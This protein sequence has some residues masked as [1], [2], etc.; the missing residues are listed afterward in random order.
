MKVTLR[1]KPLSNGSQS[2][3]LDVYEKGERRYE[4][5]R[6]YLVPEVDENTKLLNKNAL[7]KAN[8]IKS[9]FI[10]G[11]HL[12]NTANT[13]TLTLVEWF[14]E[15]SRRMQE[16]RKVS[17]AV[18]DHLHLLRP[19]LLGFLAESK[20]KNIKVDAFGRK[21]LLDFLSY[22]KD[23]KCEKRERLSQGTMVIYQQR[24]VALFNAAIVEGYV[25]TNPFDLIENNERI[26]KIIGN[27][28]GLTID[29]IKKL[30]GV[31]PCKPED[32]EVQ[33]AFLFACLTGLRLSDIRDLK[34]SDI[35]AFDTHKAI[36]KDQIKTGVLINVPLCK[37]SLQFLPLQ[38]DDNM[39]FHLPP[40]S[41]TQNGLKRIA[42]ASGI[43][44]NVTFHTSRHTFA[45]LSYESGSDL[46]TVS[47]LLG[48]TSIVTTEL[49]ADVQMSAKVAA[50][51]KL[52]GLFN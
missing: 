33:R 46:K 36:I 50:I 37:T 35:K 45:T 13:I 43:E 7:K 10:L 8:E 11:R 4:Y 26:G 22:M 28:E 24:L 52:K 30:A 40:R 12:H 15:Y 19:I 9:Q 32:A 44:K 47:Q 5:L 41:G 23:W 18:H 3:Y 51:S 2:I 1:T 27:K 39:V 14:D 49:Y 25:R 16:E 48:H 38:K 17:K 34:W 31:I 6:L 42:D 29:E 21:E 20:K